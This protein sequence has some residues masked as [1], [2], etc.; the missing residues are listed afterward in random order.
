[1]KYRYAI[2]KRI[3]GSRPIAKRP[4][5][6]QRSLTKAAIKKHPKLNVPQSHSKGSTTVFCL[7]VAS[8]PLMRTLNASNRNL[9]GSLSMRCLRS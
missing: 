1:M 4:R 2:A 9:R 3:G 8:P 6:S 7:M 5:S